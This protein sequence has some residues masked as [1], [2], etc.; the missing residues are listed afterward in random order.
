VDRTNSAFPYVRGGLDPDRAF[1]VPHTAESARQ[2]QCPHNPARENGNTLSQE[3][4]LVLLP[5]PPRSVS[6]LRGMLSNFAGAAP[7]EETTTN[8]HPPMIAVGFLGTRLLP[9]LPGEVQQTSTE[10]PPVTLGAPGAFMQ[11][12]RQEGGEATRKP[13]MMR[14]SHALLC[15]TPARDPQGKPNNGE[16]PQMATQD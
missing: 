1:S 2:P 5:L 13:K 11:Y 9:R 3:V 15:P 6:V 16:N 4:R 8:K 7:G 14:G 10:Q 12:A